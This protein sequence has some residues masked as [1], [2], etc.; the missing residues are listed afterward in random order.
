MA[1]E[2]VAEPPVGAHQAREIEAPPAATP[3]QP[4]ARPAD[5]VEALAMLGTDALRERQHRNM[6]ALLQNDALFK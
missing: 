6:A 5:P 2:T 1:V 3:P 4:A